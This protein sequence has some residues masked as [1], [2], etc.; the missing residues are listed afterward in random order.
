MEPVATVIAAAG[1]ILTI[2]A[3]AVHVGRR[4][5]ALEATIAAL[6]DATKGLR[7][8]DQAL[9]ERVRAL[10]LHRHPQPGGVYGP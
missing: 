5:G 2:I 3:A 10:E 1:L 9:A 8:A 7:A 4:L 6:V